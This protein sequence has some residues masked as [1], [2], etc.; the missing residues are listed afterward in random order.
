LAS[1]GG[2]DALRIDESDV[3]QILIA[4]AIAALQTTGGTELL[5]SRR[6]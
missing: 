1:G 5:F 2:G 3:M 4:K 6:I